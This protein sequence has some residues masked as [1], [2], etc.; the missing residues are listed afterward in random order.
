MLH[1]FIKTVL[2]ALIA[3]AAWTSV[4]SQ[5]I[6][7]EAIPNQLS[8]SMQGESPYY[9]QLGIF[10]SNLN[11]HSHAALAESKVKSHPVKVV[12]ATGRFQGSYLVIIDNC[13]SVIEARTA[14]RRAGL[15]GIIKERR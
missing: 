5:P 9:V 6:S 14:L 4:F 3:S 8:I 1:S 12:A 2:V 7:D 15:E 13:N 10:R 11:A